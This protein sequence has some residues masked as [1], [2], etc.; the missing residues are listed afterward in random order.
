MERRRLSGKGGAARQEGGGVHIRRARAQALQELRHDG[1][2]V[3]VE[4]QRA[5]APVEAAQGIFRRGGQV[6]HGHGTP[7]HDGMALRRGVL[8]AGGN[9]KG[10]QVLLDTDRPA[11]NAD[12]GIRHRGQRGVEPGA[13]HG[14]ERHRGDRQQGDDTV[15]VPGAVL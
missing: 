2:A 12:G 13:R 15:P 5:A 1:D 11:R 14:R 3:G 6:E 8:R 9:D 4:R 10:R 7:R